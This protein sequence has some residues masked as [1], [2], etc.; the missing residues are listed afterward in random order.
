MNILRGWI[1]TTFLLVTIMISA[2]PA[3]AGI[4]YGGL[5]ED[6]SG[7]AE[8]TKDGRTG[9]DLGG[10][11]YGGFTAVI[12]SITGIIFGGNLTE[13]QPIQNCGI[14]YGG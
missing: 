14:I 12:S 1:A 3:N 10:V 8:V 5:A 6:K 9:D 4:I 11:I 7:C 13:E 2:L